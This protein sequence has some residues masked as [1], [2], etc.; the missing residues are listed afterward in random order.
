MANVAKKRKISH[1]KSKDTELDFRQYS[2]DRTVVPWSSHDEWLEIQQKILDNT[3]ES[4][5]LALSRLRIWQLRCDSKKCPAFVEATIHL[6][7][8]FVADKEY[9][10]TSEVLSIYGEAINKFVQTVLERS[11]KTGEISQNKQIAE[12]LQIPQWIVDVRNDAIHH[13][14]GGFYYAFD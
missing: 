3:E 7:R 9:A 8:A 1:V 13:F 4:I 6:L 5:A 2:S 12:N 10:D 11:N 14:R